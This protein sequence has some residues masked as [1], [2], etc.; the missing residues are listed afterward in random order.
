[1]KHDPRATLRVALDPRSI[2]VIGASESVDRIGGRPIAFLK[3]FGFRG[4]VYPVNPTRDAVQGLR[5][6]AS[7]DA[8]PEVP[9]LAI[10]AV[11]GARAVEAVDACARAGVRVCVVFSSGFGETPDAAARAQERAMV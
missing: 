10:V 7:L 4:P 6:Y 8:L 11:P 2:A 1:V 5:A 9:E 3:R